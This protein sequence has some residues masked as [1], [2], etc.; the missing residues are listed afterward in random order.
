[1]NRMAT[2]QILWT[3]TGGKHVFAT[4]RTVVLVLVLEAI[5]RLKDMDANTHATLG[6][7]TEGFRATDTT[8]AT[9][10]AMK[11]LFRLGHPEVTNVA[12]IFS[13]RSSTVSTQVSVV[14]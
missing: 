3:L 2:R 1:M 7:V 6:A 9:F 8:K 13:K 11:G 14:I 12:V 5:V 10:W 4:D